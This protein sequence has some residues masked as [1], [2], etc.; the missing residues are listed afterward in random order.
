MP[1]LVV[2]LA[3]ALATAVG[4]QAP[5]APFVLLAAAGDY[6]GETYTAGPEAPAEFV[7]FEGEPIAVD[8]S[9]ANWGTRAETLPGAD[10]VARAIVTRDGATLATARLLDGAWHDR[11]ER[12]ERLERGAL[13]AVEPG[14]AL[15]WRLMVDGGL[16][17]GF[18]TVTAALSW[19]AGDGIAVRSRRA[20]FVVEIRGR[21]MAGP[22]ELAR[23]TAEWLAAQGA[24]AEAWDATEALERV[25]PDSVA[26]HLIRSRLAEASGDAAGA[27]RQLA[28]AAAVMRA[29][30][31]VLFRAFARPGQVED[32]VD[33]LVP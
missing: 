27:R 1:V 8:V 23:R 9:V 14:D 6:P 26:V 16:A 13:P 12:S 7:Y 24:A 21:E 4:G 29:D 25:Y 5:V 28:L 15:R 20:A 3:A 18:Y 33:S 11:L 22:A 17:P 31:D 32:L 30:R 10:P 19:P 2:V